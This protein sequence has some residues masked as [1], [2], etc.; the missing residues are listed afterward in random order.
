MTEESPK[1]VLN[2][3]EYDVADFTDEQR[4][5]VAHISNLDAKLADARFNVDQLSVARQAFVDMLI[6]AVD[7]QEVTDA[8]YA[9]VPDSAE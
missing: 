5:M 1:V 9:E 7:N 8:D 3:V 4:V 2:D 6:K